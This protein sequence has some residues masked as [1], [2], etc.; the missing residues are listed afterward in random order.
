MHK[1]DVALE[2]PC[3]AENERKRFLKCDILYVICGIFIFLDKKYFQCTLREMLMPVVDNFLY[4]QLFVNIQI[5][6]KENSKN[7]NNTI[8][9]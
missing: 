9:F 8:F 6:K 2:D 7:K 4:V 3:K 1:L 5:L